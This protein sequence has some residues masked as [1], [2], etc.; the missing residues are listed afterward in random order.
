MSVK[1]YDSDALARTNIANVSS[2]GKLVPGIAAAGYAENATVV[3]DGST[4]KA[5]IYSRGIQGMATY[6]NEVP[7]S[8]QINGAFFDLANLQVLKGPQG[9]LFGIATNGGAMLFETQKPTNQLEGYGSVGAGSRVVNK[10]AVARDFEA[11]VNVPIIDDTL[12]VRAG[13]ISS[14]RPGY[15]YDLAQSKWLA[16]RNYWDGRLQVTVK[17][18]AF[19]NEAFFNY[20]QADTNGM[21]IIPKYFDLN[22]FK[23]F[24]FLYGCASSKHLGQIGA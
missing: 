16:D 9:M 11:V 10:S 2:V 5:A 20:Y 4:G 12:L 14:V 18:G 6:M 15:V 23:G 21:A 24:V 17:S 19:T 1:A 8:P 3:G 13:A 22:P 7:F